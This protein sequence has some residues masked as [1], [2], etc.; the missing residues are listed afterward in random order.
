MGR[1]DRLRV[2]FVQRIGE[3]MPHCIFTREHFFYTRTI[4]AELQGAYRWFRFRTLNVGIRS[5]L[6]AML[7]PHLTDF[8]TIYETLD[9]GSEYP[10]DPDNGKM[11]HAAGWSGS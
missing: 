10:W 6:V 4:R 9:I 11:T 7:Q 3:E 2:P 1:K 5:D 8:H